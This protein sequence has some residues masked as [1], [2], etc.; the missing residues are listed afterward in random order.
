MD[1]AKEFL[2]QAADFIIFIMGCLF[3]I[4]GFANTASVQYALNNTLTDKGAAVIAD[5]YPQTYV[6]GEEV[7][8]LLLLPDGLTSVTV[9]GLTFTSEI[10]K[11]VAYIN[12]AANYMV[13][14]EAEAEGTRLVITTYVG[15]G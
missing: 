1:A 15:E 9:D 11:S 14:R 2:D 5:A 8:A 12:I 3:A 7:I 10:E 13:S 6:G 4:G